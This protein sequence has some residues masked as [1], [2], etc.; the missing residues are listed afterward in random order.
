MHCFKTI[1]TLLP[2]LCFATSVFAQ[3]GPDYE[4]PAIEATNRFKGVTWREAT[5]SSHLPKGEW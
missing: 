5:P 2:L 3:V 4:R 1:R